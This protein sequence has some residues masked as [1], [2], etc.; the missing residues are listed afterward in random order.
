MNC[1]DCQLIK[2]VGELLENLE[3]NELKRQEHL[4]ELKENQVKR[5]QEIKELRERGQQII[6][7][8]KQRIAESMELISQLEKVI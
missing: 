5:E 1:K 4:K 6:A 3:E 2:F 7:R 8:N